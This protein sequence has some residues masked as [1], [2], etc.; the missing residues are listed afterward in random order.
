M[1]GTPGINGM[2]GNGH[3]RPGMKQSKLAL[4]ALFCF[5]A[6]STANKQLKL[7]ISSIK[8]IFKLK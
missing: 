6:T 7:C 2:P 3:G 4:F 8:F 1:L 5:V